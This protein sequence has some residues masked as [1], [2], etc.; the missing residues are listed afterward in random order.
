M[1]VCICSLF[2]THTGTQLQ[3]SLTHTHSSYK[4]K[5]RNHTRCTQPTLA[6]PQSRWVRYIHGTCNGGIPP[7][8]LSLPSPEVVQ[9][10]TVRTGRAACS[11]ML[12]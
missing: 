11:G 2:S 10:W 7:A 1:R 3:P 8:A 12:R 4:H 6:H 9:A 5:S